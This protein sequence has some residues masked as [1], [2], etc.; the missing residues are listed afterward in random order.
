MGAAF[1]YE[2]L[3]GDPGAYAHNSVYVRRLMYDSIDWLNDGVMNQDVKAAFD[4]LKNSGY[5]TAGS[6]A[7]MYEMA[8]AYLCGSQSDQ[9]GV[10]GARP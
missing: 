10:T 6:A 3:R 8:L 2:T 9:S 5:I 4:Y 7:G 1:N